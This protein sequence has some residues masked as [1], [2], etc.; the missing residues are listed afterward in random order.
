M[1]LR[2]VKIQALYVIKIPDHLVGH[3]VITQYLRSQA[4]K[5]PI[6][7][8]SFQSINKPHML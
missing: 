5:Y 7:N 4:M 3:V 6:L 8:L 1:A 2:D